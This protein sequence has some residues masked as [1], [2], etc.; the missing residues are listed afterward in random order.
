MKSLG[1]FGLGERASPLRDRVGVP[2][3][4]PGVHGWIR[5]TRAACR[6]AVD[7]LQR[8][9]DPERGVAVRR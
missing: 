7:G 4:R 5:P 2:M 9:V 1:R 8:D 6:V 3:A